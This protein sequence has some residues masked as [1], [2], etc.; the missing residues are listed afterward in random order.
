MVENALYNSPNCTKI[1]RRRNDMLTEVVVINIDGEI[2]FSSI[3][4]KDT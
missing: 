3:K 1:R 4:L 2:F